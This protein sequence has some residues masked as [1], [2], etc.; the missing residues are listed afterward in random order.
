MSGS[1]PW[2]QI[3]S[4]IG[5]AGALPW[6]SRRLHRLL[7]YWNLSSSVFESSSSSNPNLILD[8]ETIQREDAT[9][10]HSWVQEDTNQLQAMGQFMELPCDGLSFDEAQIEIW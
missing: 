6:P 2:L 9:A 7:R 8:C 3:P 1:H 5:V 10:E 4:T